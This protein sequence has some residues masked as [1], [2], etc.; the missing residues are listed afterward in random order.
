[1][2]GNV[3]RSHVNLSWGPKPDTTSATTAMASKIRVSVDTNFHHSNAIQIRFL[4]LLLRLY[5]MIE[6]WGA[7]IFGGSA[8]AFLGT[9]G[10]PWDTQWDMFLALIG[11][12]VALLLL[13]RIHDRQMNRL[14]GSR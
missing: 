13:S 10:D 2:T 14:V 12:T 11:A 7:L 9:Q 8:T 5:E 4:I 1:M 3:S 6:W